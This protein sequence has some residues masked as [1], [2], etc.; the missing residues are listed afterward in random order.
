MKG[1]TLLLCLAIGIMPVMAGG[2]TTEK[3]SE[4]FK[5]NAFVSLGMEHNWA[6]NKGHGNGFAGH[7][8]AGSWFN[9][10]SGL[11]L[12]MNVGKREFDSYFSG[13]YYSV[14]VDYMYNLL[15]LFKGDYTENRFSMNLA[16]G[17]SYYRIFNSDKQN[18]PAINAAIN[19]GYN[20]S[21]HWGIFGEMSAVGMQYRDDSGSK[22]GIG[23]D[24]A[25][26]LRYY[27]NGC[28]R[29][30]ELPEQVAPVA[31][32]EDERI[33]TLG[34]KIEYLNNEVNQLRKV[35]EESREEESEDEGNVMIA[36][37]DEEGSIDIFFEEFST[38]L[39]ED[40]RNKIAAIGE[41]LK[42]N[43]F[44]VRIV[45]FSDNVKDAVID[46]T[47]RKGRTQAIIDELVEKYDIAQNRISVVNAEELGYKNL[48]GCNAKIL[49]LES[50]K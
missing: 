18:R 7:L 42:N 22:V 31:G 49:F 12:R 11:R 2:K 39:G 21:P 19:V 17:A 5:D 37:I 26:G 16:V 30:K 35:V 25:F 33:E 41:W 10:T 29:D 1:K 24:L 45:A 9:S 27:F 48:T 47:L 50:G 44:K 36:P 3:N 8:D 28:N 6:W 34:R 40:Q 23:C 32:Q 14:G 15:E 4:Y 43:T 46:E 13:G 20:F 38:F